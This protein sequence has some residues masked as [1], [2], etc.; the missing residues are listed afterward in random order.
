MKQL[1]IPDPFIYRMATGFCVA[2]TGI[3][4]LSPRLI[5]WL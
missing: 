1:A 4:M 3:S 5:G 2:E